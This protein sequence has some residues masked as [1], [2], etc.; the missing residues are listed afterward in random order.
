L[1]ISYPALGGL[2]SNQLSN[3]SKE[4][5]NSTGAIFHKT[6]AADLNIEPNI[7]KV[8]GYIDYNKFM[9]LIE[10]NTID[11]EIELSYEY[12]NA[13]FALI[14]NIPRS[15]NSSY[16]IT[17]MN[18]F[19]RSNYLSPTIKDYGLL[20]VNPS[21]INKETELL[22][23][24]I[25]NYLE[26]QHL[27]DIFSAE[28]IQ[29]LSQSLLGSYGLF[30]PENLN[31][32]DDF[33]FSGRILSSAVSTID[34]LLLTEN[35]F[36]S[37]YK[38]TKEQFVNLQLLIFKTIEQS[39]TVL[40]IPEITSHKHTE[41][42]RL[43]IA[44]INKVSFNT[45]NNKITLNLILCKTAINNFMGF[46]DFAS[47]RKSL[48]NC[49]DNIF[50]WEFIDYTLELTNNNTNEIAEISTSNDLMH[51]QYKYEFIKD[52]DISNCI[53]NLDNSKNTVTDNN[54][55]P[56]ATTSEKLLS[57]CRNSNDT[58]F[59]HIDLYKTD[60]VVA[61]EFL[62]DLLSN[63]QIKNNI[64]KAKLF[65]IFH[66]VPTTTTKQEIIQDILRYNNKTIKPPC[67]KYKRKCVVKFNCDCSKYWCCHK[68]HNKKNIRP[69]NCKQDKLN[70]N[71]I[72]KLQCLICKH[73][74]DFNP[75]T[76]HSCIRCHTKFSDYAC[77]ICKH[78]TGI[79][80]KPYHCKKCGICR[81]GGI[82]RA[83]H[84]DICGICLDVKSKNNHKCRENCAHDE[85]FICLEDTFIGC[86]ILP[87]GHKVH[88]KCAKTMVKNK[89][90][91]CSV[92]KKSFAN[93]LDVR[94]I[95]S[96]IKTTPANKNAEVH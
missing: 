26:E 74:Q 30:M 75:E 9:K 72:E 95:V 55:L 3:D 11:E 22:L 58:T 53:N 25:H 62:V 28:K 88:K 96:E 51:L 13:L 31:M 90:T 12:V 18:K 76:F 37:K 61:D 19:L 73:K 7:I 42:I 1:I 67:T 65:S 49:D 2:L 34:D 41:D 60:N 27:S 64:I 5:Y 93:Q 50:E 78:L 84:C 8:Y 86:H 52:D 80:E 57:E 91:R 38:I 70:S 56:G 94:P 81:T 71:N 32:L 23:K 47:A 15:I 35:D 48:L 14:P 54:F 29:T 68:C 69:N 4:N 10:T 92:C 77:K 20:N 44:L 83:F 6:Y 40:F 87:C 46:Y 21:L 33:N 17:S 79:K 82:D 43:P 45:K 63:F 24:N 36:D 59:N 16:K 89:I 66:N 39:K 85:C